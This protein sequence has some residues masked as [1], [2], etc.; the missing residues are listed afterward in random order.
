MG[1][2]MD[3]TE[4]R[5]KRRKKIGD[6]WEAVRIDANMAKHDDMTRHLRKGKELQRA[7]K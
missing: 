2:Y 5:E 7:T 4:R 3:E 1:L 6:E